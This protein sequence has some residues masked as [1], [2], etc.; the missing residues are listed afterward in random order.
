MIMYSIL[1]LNKKRFSVL[2]CPPYC[3]VFSK[4]AM[5]FNS[6]LLNTA[7][8]LSFWEVTVQDTQHGECLEWGLHLPL[9][10]NKQK[11]TLD[12]LQE[13]KLRSVCINCSFCRLQ[14][15]SS[16]IWTDWIREDFLHGRNIHISSGEWS[17][18]WSYSKSCQTDLWG[19]RDEGR[20]WF[21]SGNILPGGWWKYVVL[22]KLHIC[23][24]FVILLI[25]LFIVVFWHL[26]Y[27]GL[28]MM[29]FYCKVA[30]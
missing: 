14:C 10:A 5:S 24:L 21:L 13:C 27:C 16:C 4:V 9:G 12:T 22:F 30:F 17:F 28:W 23:I 2:L 11:I 3:V 1:L 29:L 18:S 19:K 25:F 8:F 15:H 20:L 26:T 7:L 6:D